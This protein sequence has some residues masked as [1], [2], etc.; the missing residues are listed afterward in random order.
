MTNRSAYSGNLILVLATLVVL[1]GVRPG[2]SGNH[3]I[4][5]LWKVAMQGDAEVRLKLRFHV[6]R[7]R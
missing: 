4:E 7:R 3:D 6:L 5:Q 1:A 2:L